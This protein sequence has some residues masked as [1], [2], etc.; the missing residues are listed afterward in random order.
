MTKI[1]ETVSTARRPSKQRPK[2]LILAVPPVMKE[3]LELEHQ[4]MIRWTACIDENNEKYIK[5]SKID[6]LMTWIGTN[7]QQWVTVFSR[8]NLICWELAYHC[9]NNHNLMY[10]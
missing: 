7:S 10:M 6:W 5:I 9:N 2:S 4:S 3:Y 1:F 8:T